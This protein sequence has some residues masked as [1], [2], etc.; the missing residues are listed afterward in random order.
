[1]IPGDMRFFWAFV[2]LA[3]S[4]AGPR[5][6]GGDFGYSLS[7]SVFAAEEFS[8]MGDVHYSGIAASG[9]YLYV[10]KSSPDGMDFLLTDFMGASVE[11]GSAGEMAA[12]AVDALKRKSQFVRSVK[13]RKD[14]I[15][16]R[17][18][19]NPYHIKKMTAFTEDGALKK[20]KLYFR[21]GF[22]E[23]EVRDIVYEK[24]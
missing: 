8:M 5:R 3:L 18:L 12:F 4:C 2:F 11:A 14:E 15:R 24:N 1:M 23:I 10:L 20:I 19:R 22:A 7:Q 9:Y 21:K 16:F 6:A 17:F 13:R